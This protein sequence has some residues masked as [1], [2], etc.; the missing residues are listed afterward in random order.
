[1]QMRRGLSVGWVLVSFLMIAGGFTLAAVAILLTEAT[2]EWVGQS[3]LFLGAL[4]GGFFAG[5]ASPGTTVAEPGLAGVLLI[6][7]MFAFLSLVP[8]TD[9]FYAAWASTATM[10]ALK[11]AFVTG[12]GGF[13][14]GLIGEKT[15][16]GEPS[17]S[18][19]RWWGISTLV[20]LGTTYLAM[21]LLA[22][23]MLRSEDNLSDGDL[24]GI[25]FVAYAVGALSSG[26]V[27]QAIAPR[28][29]ALA[30]GAGALGLFIVVLVG[31]L[32]MGSLTADMVLGAVVV[33]GVGTGVGAL[34]ARL[35]WAAIGSRRA[36]VAPVNLPQARLP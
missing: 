1:M 33:G 10:A 16:R 25:A 31:N 23:L 19:W 18:A 9:A 27:S 36:Q 6:A 14:G 3:V 21:G 26:F 20:N 5:R 11:M 28:P 17:P 32:A 12:L 8:G 29:M 15:S 2:G 4:A 35:G 22:V 24:M 13:I 34:G 30:C 7:T